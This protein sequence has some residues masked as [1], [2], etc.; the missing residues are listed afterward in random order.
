MIDIKNLTVFFKEHTVLNNISCQIND[1]SSIGLVGANG[2]GKTTFLRSIAGQID[3]E[4]NIT[5]S[6]SRK[7]H[8]IGYLP[9]DLA[10][11]PSMQLIDFLAQSA[12]ISDKKRELENC[13]EALA[14]STGEDTKKILERYE[15]LQTEFDAM[16]GFNFEIEAKKILRGLGFKPEIDASKNTATFSGGW[17]MRIALAGLLIKRPYVLLLDEPTNHLDT[18]SMEWL[19]DYLANY[20]GIIIFVSHDRHFLNKI[21]R[22]IFEISNAKLDTYSCGYDQYLTERIARLEAKKSEREAN[23]KKRNEIMALANRFRYK[24]TK[25][26]MVQ[27]RLKQLEHIT[28]ESEEPREKSVHFSFPECEKSGRIVATVTELSKSFGNNLV[29]NDVS[30]EIERGEKIALVGVNGAGK[31]TLLKLLE[32]IE[33][34][35]KGE[36]HL[37]YNVRMA[38]FSQESAQNLNYDHT[39]WE[40]VNN[41]GSLLSPQE[42][43]NLLGCFLFSGEAIQK[44]VRVLSGGEKSRLA[45]LKML[46]SPSNFLVLDEPTN[47]LDTKTKDLFCQALLEYDGTIIIVSHDREFLDALS[48]RVFEIRDGK[49]YDYHGNYTYFIEKR[50]ETLKIQ[51][52]KTTLYAKSNVT[53]NSSKEERIRLRKEQKRLAQAESKKNK[54]IASLEGEISKLEARKEEL[55]L[56][57][58]LPEVFNDFQKSE[59]VQKELEEITRLIEE[60][61]TKLLEF[62]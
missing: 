44:P 45:M 8:E 41:T 15:K 25:A 39:I 28:V 59:E 7:E 46:L 4:G 19:E 9:Q 13:E 20:T 22:K 36:A 3:Y 26:K 43:R 54:K 47:H 14:N 62:E 58:C 60:A 57:Q 31:S 12:G 50:K 30:F 27:S 48:S 61:Y 16:G 34:P 49:F 10:E 6:G 11:I 53:A 38:Y 56:A 37:G 33:S 32:G 29:F 35:S 51:T 2:A 21:A 18:E 1:K 5:V 24:A 17:K 55:T 40:E 23:I 42:K 52:Q